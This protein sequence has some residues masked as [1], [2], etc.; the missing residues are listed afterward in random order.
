[1]GALWKTIRGCFFFAGSALDRVFP[2]QKMHPYSDSERQK[3]IASQAE[4]AFLLDVLELSELLPDL[5]KQ[6]KTNINQN[7]F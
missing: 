2:P 7:L 5:L 3:R 1:M 6:A 4:G